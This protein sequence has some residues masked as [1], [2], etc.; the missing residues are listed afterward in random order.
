MKCESFSFFSLLFDLSK[1]VVTMNINVYFP[2][3]LATYVSP[4]GAIQP[5]FTSF[6]ILTKI[7]FLV[8]FRVQNTTE[9]SKINFGIQKMN[10]S[11]CQLNE[12]M[13]GHLLA[14]CQQYQVVIGVDK[15]LL[16]KP[17]TGPKEKSFCKLCPSLTMSELS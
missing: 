6:P 7:G 8:N 3:E 12:G 9:L 15:H 10:F 13:S 2:T 11:Q 4:T 5:S 14:T 1:L 16:W 17:I